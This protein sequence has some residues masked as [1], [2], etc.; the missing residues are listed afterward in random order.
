M[1]H[2][3][4]CECHICRD[5]RKEYELILG[6]RCTPEVRSAITLFLSSHMVGNGIVTGYEV[7]DAPERKF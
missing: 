5:A 6:L 3:P 7:R 4:G 2:H 1:S